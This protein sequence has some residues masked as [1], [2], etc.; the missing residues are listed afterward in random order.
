MHLKIGELIVIKIF[1]WE[2]KI[3]FYIARNN[4]ILADFSDFIVGYSKFF[5]FFKFR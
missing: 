5:H 3:I 2:N 4:I 1:L